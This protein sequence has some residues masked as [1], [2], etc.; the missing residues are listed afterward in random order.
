MALVR[1]QY[2]PLSL[3]INKVCFEEGQD[4]LNTPE[5]SR[6]NQSVTG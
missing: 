5:N 4:I 1:F 6:K 2:E 3:D